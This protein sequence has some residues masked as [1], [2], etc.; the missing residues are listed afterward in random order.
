MPIRDRNK[1]RLP[2]LG[3][4]R[5]GY[6]QE[7]TGSKGKYTFPVQSDCFVLRD[8]P[9]IEA[10]FQERGIDKPREL[11]VILPFP[12]LADNYDANYQV[13]A[14]R[15]LLC[16]GDGERILYASPMRTTQDDKGAHVYNE[17][18]PTLIANGVAQTDFTWGDEQ[19]VMG[20]IVECPGSADVGGWPHCAACKMS[21]ILKVTPYADELFEF[22]YYQ[23]STGSWRNHQTIMGTLESLP[24][25]V[26]EKK[27]PF[28]LRLVQEQ[29][30]YTDKNGKR[31][32][33]ERWFL[34]LMPHPD[35]LRALFARQA[36]EL[37][38]GEPVQVARLPAQVDYE[39]EPPSPPPYAEIQPATEDA[40]WEDAPGEWPTEEPPGGPVVAGEWTSQG[41]EPK[42]HLEEAEALVSKA[43]AQA[44][45][46][47]Q[48]PSGRPY[49]P[50]TLHQRIATVAASKRSAK[51]TSMAQ[52]GLVRALCGQMWADVNEHL[53]RLL[54]YL[55]GHKLLEECEGKEVSALIDW[56]KT[57]GEKPKDGKYTLDPRAKSEAAQ[58]IKLMQ[59]REGQQ[60]LPGLE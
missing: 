36:H 57:E 30:V 26:F 29:T 9:K 58:V 10:Y 51:A 24:P 47:P 31:Q 44:Q 34:H 41:P 3:V 43:A 45:A 37:A 38:S 28:T 42:G 6:L 12:T 20:Q 49:D 32:A 4:I 59:K 56:L 60:S 19:I 35:L 2:K 46:K 7:R 54:E 33:T 8:A 39:A 55:L 11:D 22:G 16:Q 25:I 17:P 1:R 50:D 13:W 15:V 48:P 21:A 53:P 27:L 5:L 18:G 14:N 52:I 23:I 40:E